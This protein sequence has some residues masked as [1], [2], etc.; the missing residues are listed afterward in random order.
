M[1]TAT[2]PYDPTGDA[3]TNL[4]SN[5]LHNVQP[6]ANINDASF[7]I[8]RAAPFFLKSL[9]VKKGNTA[10]AEVLLEGIHYI[11]THHFASMSYV[12]GTQIYSSITFMNR[13]YSGNVY[14][15]Y[16]TLGGQFTLDSYTGVEELTRQVYSIYSVTWE[17]VAGI[18]QGLPPYD[19]KMAGEDTTGYGDLVDAVKYL[20]ATVRDKTTG[21]TGETGT[22]ARL[23][24]HL[25]AIT[26]H[27]KDQVG[28]GR[29]ENFAIATS[30]ESRAGTVN[31]KYVTP[32]LV[33]VAIKYYLEQA[34]ITTLPVS[35][36]NLQT[37]YNTLANRFTGLNDNL[38]TVSSNLGNLASQVDTLAINLQDARTEFLNNVNNANQAID[39]LARD[40][41]NVKNT[42]EDLQQSIF[43]NENEI[44][45]TNRKLGLV[46]KSV[47][48]TNVVVQGFEQSIKDIGAAVDKLDP[49]KNPE[50]MQNFL[51]GFHKIVIPAKCKAKITLVGASTTGD[52]DPD[53]KLYEGSKYDSSNNTYYSIT[54]NINSPVATVPGAV[55]GTLVG[56]VPSHNL[57]AATV[58][59][60]APAALQ[61]TTPEGVTYT[62]GDGMTV[63]SVVF[64][65]GIS[66]SPTAAS[67]GASLLE[68]TINN[69][70]TSPLIYYVYVGQGKVSTSLPGLVKVNSGVCVVELTKNT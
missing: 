47:D 63:N 42:A 61:S 54:P 3:S 64:G 29:V 27:S 58:R 17:Q 62:G 43:F 37:N 20:A 70:T 28:L 19:H 5:E 68:T 25:N 67:A 32:L 44:A 10:N 35:V 59:S 21:G 66:G 55:S 41:L 40:V 13:N 56:R 38:N 24:A 2:Y 39:L 49:A 33:N 48:A 34:G 16:Q 9:K 57:V 15:D 23:D 45:E 69:A 6:P 51:A 4:I 53:T 8:P 46:Q 22:A 50:K 60:G 11:V 26:S 18:I 12:L 65:A 30:A 31:N 14:L 1:A 52:T 7:I 36:Q